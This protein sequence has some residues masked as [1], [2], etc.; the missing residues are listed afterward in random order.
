MVVFVCCSF[1]MATGMLLA[2]TEVEK[3][4]T[5]GKQQ[6][7][8]V[9]PQEESFPGTDKNYKWEFVW[10]NTIAFIYLHITAAY[11]LYLMFTQAHAISNITG[12]FPAILPNCLV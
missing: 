1:K 11:G 5:F 12:N 9:E 4:K 10:R 2:Q 3:P 8:K 7:K 6:P